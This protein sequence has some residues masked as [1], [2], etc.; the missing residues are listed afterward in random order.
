MLLNETEH[1]TIALLQQFHNFIMSNSTFNW[2]CVWLADAR[3]VIVPQAW[4]G[5]AGPQPYDDIYEPL[6]DKL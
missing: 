1:S 5:Q 3:N 2:W 4:F 6:W